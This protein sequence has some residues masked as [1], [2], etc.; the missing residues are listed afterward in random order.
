[1]GSD[2]TYK[3]K[4]GERVTRR[5]A[6]ALGDGEVS[7]EEAGKIS[8]YIL[9]NIDKVE[10]NVGLVD[11][12]AGLSQKW[13][14]FSSILI[15]NQAESTKEKEQEAVGQVSALVKENKI[16]EAIRV[17]ETATASKIGGQG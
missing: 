16:D 10:D 13:P 3:N 2:E 9:D 6:E 15:E 8:S 12:L 4:I 17:A 5:L 14:I 11:F 1:M 7:Q